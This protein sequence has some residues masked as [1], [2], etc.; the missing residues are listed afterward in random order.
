MT[1][2]RVDQLRSPIRLIAPTTLWEDDLILSNV[3]SFD[4]KAY[5]PDAP[6]YKRETSARPLS[7][8]YWDL[9]YAGLNP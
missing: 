3:R 7:A 2:R 4:V 9:G 8:G 5:D 6:L 1:D